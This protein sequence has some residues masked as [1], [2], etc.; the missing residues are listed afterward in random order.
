MLAALEA[1]VAL[2]EAA[3]P[4]RRVME[5]L[6]AL[7]RIALILLLLGV[8]NT[9]PIAARKLMGNRFETPVDFGAIW[10]D[11]NPLFGPH[12]T[13]RGIVASVTGTGLAAM[14]TPAGA[15]NGMLLA[16]FSMAGDLA[17]SFAKRRL[18]L[19]SGARA[20]GIDQG[21][22]AVVPLVFMK[23]RLCLS[24]PDIVLAVFLFAISEMLLSPILYR[25]GFRR[26][27]Y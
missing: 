15:F 19:S 10:F 7:N 4:V 25:M 16:A 12:K 11:G 9:L 22:E 5:N 24:W 23:G 6:P 18:G 21:I 2:A 26:N 17:A 27:P 20:L 3:G 14:L 13:W 8:A 1:L